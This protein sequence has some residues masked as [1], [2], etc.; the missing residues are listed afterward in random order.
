MPGGINLA[1]ACSGRGAMDALIRRK[2]ARRS[3]ML[4]DDLEGPAEVVE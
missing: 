2:L 3:P 4:M 1:L